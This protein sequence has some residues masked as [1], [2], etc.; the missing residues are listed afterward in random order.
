MTVESLLE[1]LNENL[2]L[3][4][5]WDELSTFTDQFGMYKGGGASFDR[6]IYNSIYNGEEQLNHETKK[7]KIKIKQPRLSI[8]GAGH[9]HK[10]SIFLICFLY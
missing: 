5:I 3:Y 6:S 10:V 9:P 2:N 7:Y 4:Q 1:E 8:I